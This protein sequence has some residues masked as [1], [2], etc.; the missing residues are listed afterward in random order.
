MA[1]ASPPPRHPFVESSP[2]DR[3]VPL[4]FVSLPRPSRYWAS[5]GSGSGTRCRICLP[6]WSGRSPRR[7]RPPSLVEVGRGFEL[8]STRSAGGQVIGQ[9]PTFQLGARRAEREISFRPNRGDL[10]HRY[11]PG[12]P[13]PFSAETPRRNSQCPMANSTW[14]GWPDSNRRH[15]AH[16]VAEQSRDVRNG[17]QMLRT[18]DV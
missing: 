6:I 12:P 1:S 5:A 17:S 18:T 15:P 3:A 11:L 2:L 10:L 8:G 16:K 4:S 7:V 13:S 14:S 9:S